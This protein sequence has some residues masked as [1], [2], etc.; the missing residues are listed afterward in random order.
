[1]LMENTKANPYD[2]INVTAMSSL[3]RCTACDYPLWYSQT[4]F[5]PS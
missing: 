4:I 2:L 3:P 1:M 5:K